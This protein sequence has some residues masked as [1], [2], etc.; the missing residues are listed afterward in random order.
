MN[1]KDLCKEAHQIAK[2]H[3]WW[4]DGDRNPL[5]ILMLINCELAEAAEEFRK[6]TPPIYTIESLGLGL[7]NRNRPGFKPEGYLSELADVWIRC[8]DY[9]EQQGLTDHF[10]ETL[11]AKMEYNKT[12]SKRHGGK[13][14]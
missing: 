6:G 10:E 4:V 13:K 9:I 3:D 14:Y 1:I 7:V 12:R 2:D 5:E 11:K 8:A